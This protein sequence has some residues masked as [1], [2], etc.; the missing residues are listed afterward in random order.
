MATAEM[1]SLDITARWRIRGVVGAS[2]MKLIA[3]VN[4]LEIKPELSNS[5]RLSGQQM[6]EKLTGMDRE[7]KGYH[8]AIVTLLED[9]EG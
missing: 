7:F 3:R 1:Q 9:Y 6:Q 4:E 2:I 8:L 5:D